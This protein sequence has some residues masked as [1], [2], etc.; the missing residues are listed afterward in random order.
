MTQNGIRTDQVTQVRGFADQRLRKKDAPLDSSNRRISMIV[1]YLEKKP[2]E[3]PAPEGDA[4]EENPGPKR[5][6]PGP[7]RRSRHPKRR[8]LRQAHQKN[9][10]TAD[11]VFA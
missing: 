11:E 5:K 9:D 1:Q 8:N 10:Q 3:E 2:S 4:K 7:A 6:S